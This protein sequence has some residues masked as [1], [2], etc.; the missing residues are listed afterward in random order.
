MRPSRLRLVNL[1]RLSLKTELYQTKS[2][3]DSIR[4]SNSGSKSNLRE[5]FEVESGKTQHAYI[6]IYIIAKFFPCQLPSLAP[7]RVKP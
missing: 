4:E 6:Y 5:D 3:S 7:V 2:E 1:T